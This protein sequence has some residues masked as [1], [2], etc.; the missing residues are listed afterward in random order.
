MILRLRE[1]GT[2]VAVLLPEQIRGVPD[3]VDLILTDRKKG[4]LL[5]SIS[6]PFAHDIGGPFAG[7]S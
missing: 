7:P 6:S 4:L 2:V 3:N 5:R 1:D